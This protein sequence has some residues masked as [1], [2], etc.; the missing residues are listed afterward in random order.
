MAVCLFCVRVVL[1]VGSGLATGWSPVQR[2]LQTVYRIKKLKKRP[3]STGAVE[4]ERERERETHYMVLFGCFQI[5][6]LLPAALLVWLAKKQNFEHY[7]QNTYISQYIIHSTALL[8]KTYCVLYM[9]WDTL[10]LQWKLTLKQLTSFLRAFY[11]KY[12]SN[13]FEKGRFSA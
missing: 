13:C 5:S 4:R 12:S 8:F 10:N 1:C 9:I 7:S 6:L 2:V 3:R 11:I